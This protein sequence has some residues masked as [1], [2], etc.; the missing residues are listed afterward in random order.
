[1]FDSQ[2]LS[3]RVLITGAAGFVGRHLMASMERVI[4]PSIQHVALIREK[5]RPMKHSSA[6]W[7]WV[8][9]ELNDLASTRQ[10]IQVYRPDI[11]IHLAAQSSTDKA[12]KGGAARTWSSN[13]QS[14]LN[15][16]E[17]LNAVNC[18]KCLLFSSS[19]EVYGKTLLSGRLTEQDTPAPQ[20][21]YASSKLAGEQIL[22]DVLSDDCKLI[23]TRPT[24]H[25]GA[26]QTDTFV[27]PNFAAQIA[28]IEAGRAVPEIRVGNLSVERD[29]IH[30]KD[31]VSAMID[32]VFN[33]TK[34]PQRSI[35]NVSSGN[36]VT[37]SSVL[38]KLIE[39]SSSRVA[40]TVDTERL[41]S[42]DIPRV[43]VSP[44]AIEEA[45]GWAPRSC[46]DSIL[47]DVLEDQRSLLATA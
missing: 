41:R 28:R 30:V 2:R 19:I 6:S 5:C 24:N 25:S 27:L 34:F 13:C 44:A 14:T 31:V 7:L 36:P 3:G 32:L 46:I 23:I 1:M 33:V 22:R 35:F 8:E 12:L 45:I 37:L 26:G 38:E 17:A 9:C 21:A 39:L 20:N 43:E 16:A 10:L 18:A 40:V 42:A 47:R 11:V 29:F 15:L 4:D